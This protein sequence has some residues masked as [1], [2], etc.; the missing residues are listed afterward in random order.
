MYISWANFYLVL[1]DRLF[2]LLFIPPNKGWFV[3][4]IKLDERPYNLRCKRKM[5]ATDNLAGNALEV[6]DAPGG[7]RERDETQN[8]EYVSLME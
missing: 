7:S 2:M 5:T 3:L 8:D 4:I 1:L 6:T